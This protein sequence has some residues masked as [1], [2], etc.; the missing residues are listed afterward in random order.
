M[1]CFRSRFRAGAPWLPW[2][3]PLLALPLVS[4]VEP[5]PHRPA[6]PVWSRSQQPVA[7]PTDGLLDVGSFTL[8]LDGQRAGREQFSVRRTTTADGATLELRSES[9]V[10][11]RRSAVR[12]EADSAGTP[13][14]YSVEQRTGATVSLRLGGQRVRGRFT[15]LS[16]RVNGEAAR[17]YL[18]S[19]GALVLEDDGVIQ[20]ALFVRFPGLAPGDSVVIPVL[21]PIGNHHGTARLSLQASGDTVAIAGSRRWAKRWRLVTPEGEERLIW[22][23]V[24][25]RLLRLRIPGRKFEALRDDVPR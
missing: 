1:S 21:T 12:L 13:L 19:P 10:G 15:T 24:D 3:V 23:D 7:Q 6:A 4:W 17:E 2:L 8:I 16:R 14:R 25:G 20:H 5:A 18:I 9:A 22:A 11:D